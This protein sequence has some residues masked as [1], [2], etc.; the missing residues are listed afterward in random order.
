MYTLYNRKMVYRT[1][2]EG[3]YVSRRG[4]RERG[5]GERDT[6]TNR[7][8]DRDR[9]K[10]RDRETDRQQRVRQRQREGERQRQKRWGRQSKR[11]RNKGTDKTGCVREELPT[12]YLKCLQG[13]PA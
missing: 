4:E 12:K 8:R 7:E 1:A 9:E 10:E 11:F 2:W 3:V 13:A 6:P 5:K